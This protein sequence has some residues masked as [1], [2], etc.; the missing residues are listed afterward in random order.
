MD[1]FIAILLFVIGA[2][3]GSFACCQVWRIK[4][5]DKSKRSH[6]MKCKHQLKWYDNIPVISWAVLGGKC[7]KCKKPIGWSE[8]FAEIGLGAIFVMTF[9]CWPQYDLLML[10]NPWVIAKFVTFLALMTVLTISFIYDLRWFELPMVSLLAGIIIG[11]VLAGIN[12]AEV[13]VAGGFEWSMLLSLGGALMILP[14][15]Y[16]V[17]YKV[18][19]ERWVGGGDWILNVALA[20]AL[21]DFWLAIFAMFLANFLGCVVCLPSSLK[22]KDMNMKIPF[23]PFLIAGF[24]IIYMIQ[25]WVFNLVMI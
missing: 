1:I 20:L 23:G 13:I 22:K 2:M 19:G 4:K 9:L 5:G 18:S 11:A 15:L 17:M 6:C 8:I 25:G 24:W 16:Y 3:M 21:T 14:G 10:G 12:F 7:R